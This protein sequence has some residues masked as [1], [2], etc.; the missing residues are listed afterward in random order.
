[1]TLLHFDLRKPV[2]AQVSEHIFIFTK[3][4]NFLK[5][6]QHLHRKL[7]IDEI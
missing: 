2:N 6:Q 5:K 1:M 3:F 7:H 4:K